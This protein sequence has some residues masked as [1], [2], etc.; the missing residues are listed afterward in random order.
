[1]A[2]GYAEYEQIKYLLDKYN[3]VFKSTDEYEKYIGE[4]V[5][6]LKV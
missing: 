1:M 3:L 5:E 4:L 2:Y 6:I